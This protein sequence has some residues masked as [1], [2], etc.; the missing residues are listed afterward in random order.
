MLVGNVA[1]DAV[2]HRIEVNGDV[3]VNV[4]VDARRHIESDGPVS[5]KLEGEALVVDAA[6][7]AEGAR[8][9][10]TIVVDALTSVSAKG[11]ARV[12]IAQISSK[13]L[14]LDASGAATIVLASGKGVGALN[15]AASGTSHVDADQVPSASVEATLAD[16]ARVEVWSTERVQCS[17]KRASRLTVKGHPK[18]V[19]K[20][21]EGVA[22]Y[23]AAP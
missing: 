14:A 8:P 3:A 17:L 12:D 5:M 22:R 6:P 23:I 16:A 11:S 19:K 1:V 10:V 9:T 20:N 4:S 13:S 21:V 18:D 2:V 7:H 15:V